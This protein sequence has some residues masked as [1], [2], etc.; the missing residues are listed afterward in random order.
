MEKQNK[1]IVVAGPTAVGKTAVAIRLARHFG[2]HIVSADARQFFREMTIGTAKPSS[3]ELQAA[4]HHFIDTHSV[5]QSYDAAIYADDALVCIRTLFQQH[6]RVIL[7]GGSGLYIKAVVDGFDEIPGVDPAI[8]A[9]LQAEYRDGGLTVLQQKLCELDP[10]Q[11]AQMDSKNPQRLMRALEVVMGTGKSIASFQRRTKR[12]PG[13]GVI[14]IGL[15]L[16]RQELYDR[17]DAR[18]DK[19]IEDGLFGEAQMLYPYRNQNALQTVGYREIF[20]FME[21]KYDRAEAVRLL[22]QHSRQYAKRQL[23][24]FKRDPEMIWLHP[25]NISDIIDIASR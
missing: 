20:D 18:M 14:K 2:T 25:A 13:F 11:F 12:D 17:I 7:C 24:W 5:T 1:L 22:R 4:P 15:D 6:E 9:N 21:G 19:M 3:D 10:V 8:R 16:P 23:T